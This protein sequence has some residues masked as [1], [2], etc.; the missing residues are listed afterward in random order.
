MARKVML[1]AI[2][3]GHRL[4]VTPEEIRLWGE[5]RSGLPAIED[6]PPNIPGPPIL[7]IVFDQQLLNTG[8]SQYGDRP[9]GLE[10]VSWDEW[11]AEL[12][13]RNLALKVAIEVPGML[14]D[15]YEF[16]ELD[17]PRSEIS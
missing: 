13:V 15:R 4:L 1:E 16:V 7:R 5:A 12:E 2:N 14:D 10:L 9:G 17:R 8:E 11:V 3:T 6:R